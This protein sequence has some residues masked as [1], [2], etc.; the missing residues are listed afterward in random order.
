MEFFRPQARRSSR[1]ER[2]RL[3][4]TACSMGARSASAVGGRQSALV[5]DQRINVLKQSD[6]ARS[7][8]QIQ[9]SQPPQISQRCNENCDEDC[10]LDIASPA[11]FTGGNGPSKDKNCFQVENHKKHCSEIELCR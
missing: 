2:I 1:R 8:A 10:K 4:R 3:R 9:S 11:Q 6:A 5:I 7:W